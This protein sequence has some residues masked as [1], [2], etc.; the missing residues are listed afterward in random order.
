VDDAIVFIGPEVAASGWRLAGVQVVEP[1]P[2][3]E[4]AALAR[5]RERAWMVIVC[6]SVVAR[7]D[8]ASWQAASAATQ[9]LLLAVPDMQGRAALPDLA[10]RLRGMLGLAA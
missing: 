8:P 10:A 1:A 5:A 3:E 7:L 6:A 4:A 2:G 9:P